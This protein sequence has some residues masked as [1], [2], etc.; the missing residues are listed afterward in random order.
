MNEQ[1]IT[2]LLPD[3]AVG[4]QLWEAAFGGAYFLG[5]ILIA[6]VTYFILK[7][8]LKWFT[9]KTTSSIDDLLVEAIKRPVIMFF[10]VL[11]PWPGMTATTYLDRFQDILDRALLAA[12]ILVVGY[13]L[14]RVVDAVLKWYGDEIAARTATTLDDRVLPLAQRVS[15]VVIYGIV[16][17]LVLQSQGLNVSPLLA[18]LGI[19]GLAVAL[20]IQPTL[21]NFVAGTYTVTES[22]IGE[23]DFIEMD[24]GASGWVEH[25]G[26][27]TTKVRTFWNNRLI[28]PNGKLSESVVTN[29]Q[30]PDPSVF[31]IVSGGV[32]YD[33]DLQHVNDVALDVVN[34]VLS[35]TDRADLSYPP[36]RAF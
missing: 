15:S 5:S 6:F 20:A 21:S 31:S 13:L 1:E 3:F 17:M 19:G 9:S 30:G 35:R 29:Y 24:G 2:H 34:D 10:I 8:V 22:G 11:G 12:L 26:W 4:S 23:G 28:I 36:R 16:V 27:R 18:G 32:S 7:N 33:S 25:V 14:K